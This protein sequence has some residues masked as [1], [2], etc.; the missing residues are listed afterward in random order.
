MSSTTFKDTE[1]QKVLLAFLNKS[2]VA[3]PITAGPTFTVDKEG[4]V[5]VFPADDG[6]SFEL[7]AVAAG[8]CVV[9][10]SVTT[11]SGAI[12][13]VQVTTTVTVT[14][15]APDEEVTHIALTFQ[16]PEAQ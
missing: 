8:T 3:A 15:V 13:T 9:T 7:E 6:S 10:I 16:T 14:V 12:V 5:S 4:V 11:K 1:K 2:E